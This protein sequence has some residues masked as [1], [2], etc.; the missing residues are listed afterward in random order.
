VL[1]EK[2]Q[3]LPFGGPETET[4][5]PERP[6]RPGPPRDGFLFALFWTLAAMAV[7]GLLS[8]LWF[9]EVD[10]R[11]D[12]VGRAAAAQS[13][14][15]AAEARVADLQADVATLEEEL[16]D[17]RAELRPWRLRSGRRGEALRSTRG[18][19]ALVAPL[20][21]SYGDVNEVIATVDGDADAVVAAAAALTREVAA[22]NT[23]LRRTEESQLS[24]RVLRKHVTTLLAR[25]AALRTARSSLA[26]AQAGYGVAAAR[27]ESGF[28][29]LA[30]AVTAL[31]K[32]IAKALE[33]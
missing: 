32:Q 15:T 28:E 4:E 24:E 21:E 1:N 29:E 25:G 16:A 20:R 26:E 10:R 13:E 12:A 19:L 6:P 2:T 7:I 5:R 3:P 17:V 18:V 31:R 33:R 14:V 30:K 22:L 23:Y 11:K 27:V 8:V 9:R